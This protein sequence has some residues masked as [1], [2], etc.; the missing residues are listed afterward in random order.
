MAH[1]PFPCPPESTS[2]AATIAFLSR[3]E[4]Y[5]D[6]TASVDV[7][8]THMS[9][10]FL[11]ERYAYKLKKPVHYPFLDLSTLE[12]RR[13][14]SE[15]EVRLN[16]R[17]A[18]DV[19]LGV[20]ALT[21][22]T[23]G[24][25]RLEGAGEPVEWL[26]KMQRLPDERML[27][28][29]IIARRVP[30]ERIAHAAGL[31]VDFYRGAPVVPLEAD[32]YRRRI[33]D[34]LETSCTA[35]LQ[36]RYGLPATRIQTVCAAQR[37]FVARHP[38]MIGA[39][40]S[41]VL[42]THGDLR[43]EH[44]C[45]LPAPVIIDCLEFNRDFRL[46]DPVDELSFLALECERLGDRDVGQV[47]LDTYREATRDVPPAELIAFYQSLWAMLRA[48]LCAWH[49]DDPTVSARGKWIERALDY[50]A[51]AETRVRRLA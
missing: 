50:L 24:R 38:A 21:R 48:R 25:L 12:R 26:V 2:L 51:L 43:P 39:R 17:L 1:P 27:D 31:L 41:R 22:D 40:A 44:V 32:I 14:N 5:P 45:L 7:R 19:Y 4:N 23:A 34:R 33:N 15:E 46:L 16:R 9:W 10:V 49:L 8:E 47:F 42:E 6:P 29:A 13:H 3:S 11:T 37:S 35:L 36:P 20:V 18:P 30:A 28:R